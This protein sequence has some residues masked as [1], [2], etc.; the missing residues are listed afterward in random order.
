M[1]L[2]VGIDL[3]EVARVARQLDAAAGSFRTSVFTAD[4]IAYCDGKHFPAQHYAARFAAKE[5][6]LKALAVPGQGGFFWRDVEITND[7]DGRPHVTLHRRAREL[8]AG[9]GVAQVLV[10]LSHVHDHAVATAIAEG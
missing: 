1:I 2:G 10:S 9:R 4:E 7:K 5:A 3:I 8:A 6:V